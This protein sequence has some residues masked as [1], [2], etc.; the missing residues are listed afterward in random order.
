MWV[1]FGTTPSFKSHSVSR[2]GP[3]SAEVQALPQLLAELGQLREA[4]LLLCTVHLRL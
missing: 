1:E 3:R 2:L 4:L